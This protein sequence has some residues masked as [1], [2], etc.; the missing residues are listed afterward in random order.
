M[1]VLALNHGID[2][3]LIAMNGIT[4][5]SVDRYRI[6]IIVGRHGE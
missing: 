6:D 1:K 5:G 2:G 3:M 4:W